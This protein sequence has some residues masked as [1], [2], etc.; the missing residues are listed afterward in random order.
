MPDFHGWAEE[1]ISL[2]LDLTALPT[3]RLTC[4][5]NLTSEVTEYMDHKGGAITMVLV[6]NCY[7]LLRR[8]KV[9]HMVFF[10]TLE[11]SGMGIKNILGRRNGKS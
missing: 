8:L 5:E 3:S 6:I 11:Q 1:G 7:G 2:P 10:G 4:K 9:W